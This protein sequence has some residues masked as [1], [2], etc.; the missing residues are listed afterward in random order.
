RVLMST[1]ACQTGCC[2]LSFPNV[3]IGNSIVLE[4]GFL[5]KACRNDRL[6]SS[7][8]DTETAC[9]PGPRSKCQFY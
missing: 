5:L 2:K 9:G 6:L 3:F 8:D 1:A 7:K 4:A